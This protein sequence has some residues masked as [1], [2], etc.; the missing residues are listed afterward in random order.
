MSHV[1]AEAPLNR[2]SRSGTDAPA[3]LEGLRE[4][5]G[6]PDWMRK[7]LEGFGDNRQAIRAFGLDVI[8]DLC[9][10][11]LEQGAPGLHFYTLNQADAILG[12]WANLGLEHPSLEPV[13]I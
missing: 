12:I 6:A 11:L 5:L 10:R 8:S 4:R 3:T 13:L 2:P 7:R 9:Q 1:R